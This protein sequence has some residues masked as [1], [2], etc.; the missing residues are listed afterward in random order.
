[1]SGIP[2]MLWSH[3]WIRKLAARGHCCS[4]RLRVCGMS[5]SLRGAVCGAEARNVPGRTQLRQKRPVRVL[6]ALS[7]APA[8]EEDTCTAQVPNWPMELPG[9]LG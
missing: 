5:L 1:M 2:C 3:R 7:A 4:R 8:A 9:A 6:G